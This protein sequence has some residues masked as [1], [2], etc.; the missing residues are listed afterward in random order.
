MLQFIKI[1]WRSIGYV[2]TVFGVYWL[3]KDVQDSDVAAGPWE[4]VGS[5]FDQNTALW[6]VCV[7]LGA[8]LIWIDV[9]PFVREKLGAKYPPRHAAILQELADS[10]AELKETALRTAGLSS[11]VPG[12][13]E[14]LYAAFD[15]PYRRARSLIEQISYDRP[16]A[17][18]A[19]DF[20]HICSMIITDTMANQG[21]GDQRKELE[22][23]SGPIFRALH[24]GKSIN[25]AAI[26]LPQWQRDT[27]P[28]RLR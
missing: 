5:M 15:P 7:G 22:E 8:W 3:P 1:C 27:A 23:M 4:R 17:Q 19:R 25:R 11:Y 9:R 6:I 16:T 20:V 12:S 26:P 14:R 10:L 13:L 28:E 24:S 18:T 21:S 2:L